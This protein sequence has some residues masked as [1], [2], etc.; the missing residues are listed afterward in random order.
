MR[1]PFRLLM[2]LTARCVGGR[3]SAKLV[4]S[5][6]AADG[7]VSSSPVEI[8]LVRRAE[9]GEA[10]IGLTTNAGAKVALGPASLTPGQDAACRALD[11]PTGVTDW[12]VVSADMHKIVGHFAFE[13]R[14]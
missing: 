13:I 5:S 1:S 8:P 10:T 12:H 9:R 6:P 11:L 7:A 14:P 2:A 3:C 4:Q